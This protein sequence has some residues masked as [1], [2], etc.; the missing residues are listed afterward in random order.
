VD[1][2][3][4]RK[5][6]GTGLG[7]TLVKRFVELHGGRITVK[8]DIGRGSQ[9][10]FRIP[11]APARSPGREP[12]AEPAL[13]EPFCAPP[14]AVERGGL[15]LIV[16]DNPG[17]MKLTREILV[18]RGYRVLEAASGEEALDA[19]KFI[20]PDLI[21]MDLQLPGM[22][23]LTVTRRLKSDPATRDIP[24]LALTAHAMPKDLERALEA[25][26]AGTIAKP[27]DTVRFPQRVAATLRGRALSDGAAEGRS[28]NA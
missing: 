27:I 24:T 14:D 19:L 11:L 12:I 28:E 10:T 26:C 5:Y 21:L 9:F 6:Q 20:H 25:G 23:G 17:N 13:A 7:L 4:A 1:G 18:S 16:E 8:S 2:S 3:Y 15:I 22:D